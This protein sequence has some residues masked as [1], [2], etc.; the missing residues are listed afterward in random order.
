MHDVANLLISNTG[1]F[2]IAVDKKTVVEQIQTALRQL[3]SY[4]RSL[5]EEM[6]QRHDLNLSLR[7]YKKALLEACQQTRVCIQVRTL[8]SFF[9]RTDMLLRLFHFNHYR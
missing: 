4:N 1:Y 8:N 9:V 7:A 2:T 6:V 3:E 5:D